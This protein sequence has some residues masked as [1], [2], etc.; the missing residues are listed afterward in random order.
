VKN[1]GKN[2]SHMHETY[3]EIDVHTERPEIGIKRSNCSVNFLVNFIYF[4]DKVE[5]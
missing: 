5:S 4:V 2:L 3:G 1:D